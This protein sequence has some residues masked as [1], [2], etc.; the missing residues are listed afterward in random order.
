[1]DAGTREYCRCGRAQKAV[2]ARSKPLNDIIYK[3]YY[4]KYILHEELIRVVCHLDI[5]VNGERNKGQTW[6]GPSERWQRCNGTC[7]SSNITTSSLVHGRWV[8][9]GVHAT[10]GIG[11]AHSRCSIIV[12]LHVAANA[13]NKI[14]TDHMM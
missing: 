10:T 11:R 13:S 6:R 14:E 9:I 4:K 5:C 1:M 3:I 12:V 2:N 8:R 7:V